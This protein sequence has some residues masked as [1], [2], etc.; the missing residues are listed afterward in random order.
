MTDKLSDRA[1]A[2]LWVINGTIPG[3]AVDNREGRDFLVTRNGIEVDIE[4]LA[5]DI[6]AFL[7]SLDASKPSTDT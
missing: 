2:V 5:V 1:E 4:K 3:A 6:A 7:D